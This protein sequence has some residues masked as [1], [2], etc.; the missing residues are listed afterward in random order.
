MR[1]ANGSGGPPLTAFALAGL[2]PAILF[3]G[4]GCASSGGKERSS[5][6]AVEAT[7]IF[8]NS[9]QGA[10]VRIGAVG[11]ASYD[12]KSDYLLV[13]RPTLSPDGMPRVPADMAQ[14]IA[15]LKKALPRKYAGALKFGPEGLCS[16]GTEADSALRAWM[17]VHWSLHASKGDFGPQRDIRADSWR[18]HAAAQWILDWLCV[19]LEIRRKTDASRRPAAGARNVLPAS[20][21]AFAELHARYGIVALRPIPGPPLACLFSAEGGR[22]DTVLAMGPAVVG[23]KQLNAP[24]ITF[25]TTDPK[26]LAF[27]YSVVYGEGRREFIQ[28]LVGSNA[29]DVAAALESSRLSGTFVTG[30]SGTVSLITRIAG[31]SY[32]IAFASSQ[33]LA[34]RIERWQ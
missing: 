34:L 2:L 29:T 24:Y 8:D 22:F 7:L 25:D 17:G 16:T 10:A 12:P 5:V 1:T 27:G 6:D 30:P 4:A 15:E 19:D 3:L 26:A 9:M 21:Q 23:C 20:G 31:F 13:I 33:P 11:T 32:K 14:A 18:S 28:Q